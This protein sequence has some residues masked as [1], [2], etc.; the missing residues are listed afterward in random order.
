[1]KFGILKT[2]IE[3]KLVES[4]KN[5]TL[6]EDLNYFRK[7]ILSDKDFCKMMSVY[8]NL[9][10]NKN[11]D[12]ETA[13]FIV[14]DLVSEFKKIKLKESTKKYIDKWT[15]N[16]TET[17]NYSLIDNLLYLGINE[18]DEKTKSK[19]LVI[20]SLTKKQV[21]KKDSPKLPISMILNV[22]NQKANEFLQ[23]LDESDR[24]KVLEIIKLDD[25]S[26]KENFEKLKESTLNKIDGLINES[27]GEL[28]NTL[29]ETK[30]R[31]SISESNK[32]EYIKL[33]DLNKSL[34]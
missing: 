18:I 8:D 20:E 3:N 27:E 19:K 33:L 30:N 2:K 24:T 5:N 25:S 6:K 14:D 11:V 10:E 16:I 7:N 12:K 28:K 23:N 34:L 13:T 31:I 15:K 4:F 9:S 26:L 21:D 17:S 1:M 32:K 29:I 22:A